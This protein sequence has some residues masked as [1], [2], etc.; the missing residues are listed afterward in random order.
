M[1]FQTCT[2]GNGIKIIHAQV[3]APVAHC[4]FFIHTGSRD[5]SAEE[6]GMAHFAE[7]IF[8][9]STHKRNTF[10]I[11]SRL[12]DVGGDLNAYTTKEE[13]CLQAS[14]MLEHY[15]RALELISDLVFNRFF[16][17]KDVEKEKEVVIDEINSYRDTPSENIFDDFD[18]LM[19]GSHPIAH[20]ILGRA[21]HVRKFTAKCIE[22]FVASHYFTDR[23][24]IASAG[25]VP[26]ARLVKWCE[27]H[28]GIIPPHLCHTMRQVPEPHGALLLETKKRIHQGHCCLGAFGYSFYDP[29]R[30]CLSLLC[31]LLGGPGMNTRLN[32]ALRE[33]KGLSYS[34]EASFTPF[35]D[36]GI[37]S[38]YFSA[39]KENT[40]LCLDIVHKE[41]QKLRTTRLGTM[42]LL[43][44]QR[45]MLGQLAI[46]CDSHENLMLSIGKSFLVYDKVDTLAETALR[47]N[48]ITAGD[49]LGTANEILTPDR[50][51]TLI[52]R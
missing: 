38:I 40:D 39:D 15:E 22:Q 19:F 13:T 48:R 3:S 12:E 34:A 30:T 18:E 43:R 47:I 49:L 5:E 8:F 32:M 17:D 6:I 46:S 52:Y 25:A 42:Q 26:F 37:A 9:K 33:H 2:L 11:L 27:K 20:P 35:T 29:R 7:H 14:F 16:Q 41:L 21:V 4:G 23:M 31:N 51:S 36:T 44:A 10:Q 50:I 24:V 28:F 1:E 45:Q